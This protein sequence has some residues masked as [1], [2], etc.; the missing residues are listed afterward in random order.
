MLFISFLVSPAAVARKVFPFLKR[1][2]TV[3]LVYNSLKPALL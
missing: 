3:P 1:S 2:H